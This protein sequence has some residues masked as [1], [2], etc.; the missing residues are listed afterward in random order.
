VPGK[1][2]AGFP[3]SSVLCY[4]FLAVFSGTSRL[5]FSQ[6]IVE[7]QRNSQQRQPQIYI[8]SLCRYWR[9]SAI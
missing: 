2:G 9:A 5:R 7:R 1:Q 8:T 6:G 4:W 3:L